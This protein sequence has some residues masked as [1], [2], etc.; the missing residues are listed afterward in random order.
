MLYLTSKI[1]YPAHPDNQ[2]ILIGYNMR[3]PLLQSSLT[4]FASLP[5]TESNIIKIMECLQKTARQVLRHIVNQVQDPPLCHLMLILADICAVFFIM[6]SLGLGSVFDWQMN[7][8]SPMSLLTV[9]LL[10]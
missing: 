4:F 10:D 1:G 8:P 7:A 3:Q 6:E 5:H 9:G 2:T